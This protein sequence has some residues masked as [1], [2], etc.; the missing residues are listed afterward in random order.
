MLQ[1]FWSLD[2]VPHLDSNTIKKIQQ[3]LILM[4]SDTQIFKVDGHTKSVNYLHTGTGMR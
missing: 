1:T 3:L 4:G 2:N